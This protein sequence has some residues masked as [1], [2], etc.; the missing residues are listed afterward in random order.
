[1]LKLKERHGW[2]AQKLASLLEVSAPTVEKY[3]ARVPRQLALK[4]AN[5]AN[6]HGDRDLELQ[7]RAYAEGET[8]EETRKAAF[9]FALLPPD[10][11]EIAQIAA[12]IYMDPT[13]EDPL[14]QN[15]GQLLWRMRDIRS[16]SQ[17]ERLHKK[18]QS[19]KQ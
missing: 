5:L 19:K 16:K 4:L 12:E 18:R 10:A 11:R 6:K 9:D 7:F 15:L 13:P 17:S 14:E 2:S 8:A 1:M 3:I